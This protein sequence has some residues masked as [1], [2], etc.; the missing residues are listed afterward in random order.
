MKALGMTG[1]LRVGS[2]YGRSSPN[3]QSFFLIVLQYHLR[4][5]VYFAFVSAA[6]DV[7]EDMGM[8]F[9]GDGCVAAYGTLSAAAENAAGASFEGL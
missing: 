7:A 6:E 9:E 4:V 1:S 2:C 5:A 8:A 3:G